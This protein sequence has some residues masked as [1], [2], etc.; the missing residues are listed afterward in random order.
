MEQASLRSAV[1][2]VNRIVASPEL[3]EKVRTNPQ[4]E[5]PRIADQFVR[6]L[7]PPLESDPWIYRIV[8][9]ALGSTV[10]IVVAGAV[11]LAGMHGGAAEV[12]IP[13]VLTAIGSAAVGALAG[14]LAPSPASRK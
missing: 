7:P 11:L 9:L 13:E 3:T 1:A 14:L 5:L 4:I 10:L 2:L 8:V 12:R 6:E